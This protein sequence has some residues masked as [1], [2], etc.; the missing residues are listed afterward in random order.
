M[1]IIEYQK[2][3]ICHARLE[4][5]ILADFKNLHFETL[6]SLSLSLS[7]S[8]SLAVVATCCS[9]ACSNQESEVW[10]GGQDGAHSTQPRHWSSCG[11]GGYLM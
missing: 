9:R 2:C 8:F 5:S 3:N 4:I 6:F 10:Q 7:L 11:G 1:E